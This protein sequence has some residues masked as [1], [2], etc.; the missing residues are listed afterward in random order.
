MKGLVYLL[1][2]VI[3]HDASNA[4]VAPVQARPL[5]EDDI[6]CTKREHCGERTFLSQ[7]HTARA[8]ASSQKQLVYRK[9]HTRLDCGEST[10][11]R[12]NVPACGWPLEHRRVEMR[13]KNHE[14]S[15]GQ[16]LE[17]DYRLLETPTTL[18]MAV[19]VRP[20]R[21]TKPCHDFRP[22]K[23]NPECL[24]VGLDHTHRSLAAIKPSLFCSNPHCRRPA[25]GNVLLPSV[26]FYSAVW[27]LA[28]T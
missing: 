20:H 2:K 7:L 26:S 8:R 10:T 23:Q 3:Y 5:R 4:F 27:S 16:R 17:L 18:V 11:S 28:G 1:V 15:T 6:Q 25:L 13:K 19:M 9:M 24:W 14:K 21:L 22:C 12:A